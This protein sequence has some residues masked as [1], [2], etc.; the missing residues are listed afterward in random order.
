MDKRYQDWVERLQAL[1]G[2]VAIFA[3]DVTT[4]KN[5]IPHLEEKAL[6]EFL[7]SLGAAHDALVDLVGLA[8]EREEKR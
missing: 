3:N 6:A 7:R 1:R 8:E 4:A 2:D 5:C